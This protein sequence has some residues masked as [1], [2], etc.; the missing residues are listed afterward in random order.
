MAIAPLETR[1]A[2]CHFRSRTEARWAVFFNALGIP[3]QYEPQGFAIGDGAYL[4]DF[5]LPQS[6]TWVEVKG[7]ERD[8]L[9]KAELYAAAAAGALPDTE[10]SWGTDAGLLLLGPVPDVEHGDL[11]PTHTVIQHEAGVGLHRSFV[12]FHSQRSLQI[13]ATWLDTAQPPDLPSR[14]EIPFTATSVFQDA[15]VRD[16]AARAYRAAREAR[17]EHGELGGRR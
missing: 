12:A 8:V 13:V 15:E 7:D 11:L 10:N 4:P 9:N 16:H 17:F 6:R 2:G 1:Y 14:R 5:R 3:W